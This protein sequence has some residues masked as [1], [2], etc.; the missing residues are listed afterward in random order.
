LGLRVDRGGV[1]E[2]WKH[3]VDDRAGLLAS[4]GK[5]GA[6]IQAGL[7]IGVFIEYRD[8]LGMTEP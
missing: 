3:V 2:R 4:R 5:L 1:P 6:V 8:D 7:E